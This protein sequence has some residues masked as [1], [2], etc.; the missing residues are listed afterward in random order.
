[1]VKEANWGELM[2]YNYTYEAIKYGYDKSW[3]RRSD[4]SC[5]MCTKSYSTIK[6]YTKDIEQQ[7]HVHKANIHNY[8]DDDVNYHP[9]NEIGCTNY[10][11]KDMVKYGQINV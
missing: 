11:G 9:C 6:N 8:L 3:R 5:N 1:M 10:A 4:I 2:E 7:L